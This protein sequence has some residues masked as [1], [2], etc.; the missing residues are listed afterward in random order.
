[1]LDRTDHRRFVHAIG[2]S[3]GRK[4]LLAAHAIDHALLPSV[5]NRVR[6][7]GKIAKHPEQIN[8]LKE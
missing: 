6:K 2:I 1:M 4:A 3:H 8:A 7:N 5:E